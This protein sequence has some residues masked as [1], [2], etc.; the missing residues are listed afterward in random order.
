M[1]M[2]LRFLVCS[3]GCA[4][5]LSTQVGAAAP[6]PGAG[7]PAPGTIEAPPPQASQ[8][9]PSRSVAGPPPAPEPPMTRQRAERARFSFGRYL[10]ESF[11]SGLAVG[12]LAYGGYSAACGNDPCIGGFLLSAV[13]S[14]GVTP[15]GTWIIG[16]ALGGA[17]DLDFTYLV[18]LSP[19][20]V[21]GSASTESPLFLFSLQV[22]LEPFA[23]AVGYEVSS[24][25]KANK[26][27]HAAGL[28]RP[29]L[30]PWV[31]AGGHMDGFG[32]RASASF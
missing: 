29:R 16:N 25:A 17:G 23:A 1:S 10:V 15:L 6:P 21:T 4:L 31:G 14:V 26:L 13:V 18:G 8:D 22:A 3:I 32:L 5:A 7:P 30:A 20:G 27:L 24:N 2:N 11:G 28:V 19:F 12:L 9:T